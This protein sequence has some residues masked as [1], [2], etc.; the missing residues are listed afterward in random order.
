MRINVAVCV[1]DK[2]EVIVEGP[3]QVLDHWVVTGKQLVK[4]VGHCGGSES[5]SGVN[6]RTTGKV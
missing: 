4:D 6:S 3:R 1:H 2:K 5:I